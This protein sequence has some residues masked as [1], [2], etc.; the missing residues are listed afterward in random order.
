MNQ[1]KIDN[2][3]PIALKHLISPHDDFKK[4]KTHD[5]KIKSKY[6]G[7]IASFGPSVIQA[8][9]AKTLAFYMKGENA[10]RPVIADF[11]KHVLLEGNDILADRNKNKKLLNIYL[12][13]TNGKTTLQKLNFRDKILEAATACKLAMFTYEMVEEES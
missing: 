8:G 13:E 11:V 6:A 7:Y 2:M 12:D 1:K 3:I 5:G 10:D 9:I 4:I